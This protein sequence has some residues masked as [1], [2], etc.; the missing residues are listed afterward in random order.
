MTLAE[1]IGGIDGRAFI[2][3]VATG[4]DVTVR[5][6][7]ANRQS[8]IHS[9]HY[10]LQQFL[11]YAALS[12]RLLGDSGETALNAVGIAYWKMSAPGSPPRV[13]G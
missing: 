5:M 8:P 1:F 9:G 2:A 7:L 11:G 13:T 3:G 10:N 4:Q 12:A 6:A